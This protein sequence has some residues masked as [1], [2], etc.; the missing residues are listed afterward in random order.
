M[1][2]RDDIEDFLAQRRIA[3]VG[4]SRDPKDFSRA[5]FRDMCTLGYDMVPVNFSA[6][7]IDG[8]P[9]FSRV[10]NIEP[11]VEG[12]LLMT[13]PRETERV[14]VECADAGIPR[15][16]MYRGVGPGAVSPAAAEFCRLNR[17]RL[18]EGYCPFMFLPK[19]PW[20]HRAHGFLLKLGHHYPAAA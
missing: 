4:V 11:P 5:L 7:E 8:K 14:V 16:W 1:T 12:A 10:K 15:V 2:T 3:M 19:T 18:V 17:I 6:S 9:C 20:F 13:S